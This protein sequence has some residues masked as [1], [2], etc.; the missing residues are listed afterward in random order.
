MNDFQVIAVVS[1][2]FLVVAITVFCLKTSPGLRI[3]YHV[4]SNKTTRHARSP[5][6]KYRTEVIDLNDLNSK[7]HPGFMV[8]NIS[9]H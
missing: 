8:S 5:N 2:F 7:P 6:P 1:V 9:T 4:N 3:P